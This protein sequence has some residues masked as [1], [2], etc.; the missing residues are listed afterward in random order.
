MIQILTVVNNPSLESNWKQW[1]KTRCD[2]HKLLSAKKL[3]SKNR[4]SI[5]RIIWNLNKTNLFSPEPT[6]WLMKQLIHKN[7]A[8]CQSCQSCQ[9]DLN[10]VTPYFSQGWAHI[11]N[12]WC[13]SK[14]LWFFYVPY[15]HH[16]EKYTPTFK[17]LIPNFSMTIY[18]SLIQP[19]SPFQAGIWSQS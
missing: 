8:C 7:T 11:P 6:F 15:E 16:W 4:F 5:Q 3:C 10:T 9:S 14:I 1:L 2:V 19:C 18:L 13:E 12:E 17:P